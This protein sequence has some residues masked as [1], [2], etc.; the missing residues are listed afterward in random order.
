LPEQ[1]SVSGKERYEF[2][3]FLVDADKQLLLRDGE[4][5]PVTPKTFQI[6]LALIRHN[7]EVVTKDDLMKEVWPDTFVEEANL[8]RNIFLLRKALGEDPPDH[9]Y[10]VTL[11]GRGYRLAGELRVIP[12][13]GV[14]IV[15]A[16]HSRVELRVE[17]SQAWR[18]FAIAAMLV[19]VLAATALLVWIRRPPVLS[20]KDTLVI[21]D[22]ANSTG[23]AVFDGTL[24]QGLSVQLQ[25]SPYLSLV[26][27]ERIHQ[28]LKLMGRDTGTQ[29]TPAVAREVC[30]RTQSAAFLESSISSLGTKYVIGVKAENCKTGDVVDVEQA[31]AASKEEVLTV[32]TQIAGKF[33]TKIGESLATVE[34]HN[35]SLAEA[36]TPS[37]EALRAY[38]LGWQHMFG[39][40]GAS[41]AIPYFKRAIDLDPNFASAYAMAG[42]AYGDMGESS[43]SA[44][45]LT[46]AYALRARTSDRERLFI[47]VNHDMQVSGDLETARQTAEVWAQTYPRDVVPQML[48]SFLYQELGK[49]EKSL[50]AG[51]AAIRL[52]P[53]SVPGYA[54]LAW[55]YVLLDRYQEA[56]N[57]VQ[58]AL[59]RNLDFPDLH[60]L[61]YDLAFM[62]GDRSA[63]QRALPEAEG[64]AGAQHWLLQR[65]SCVLA[66]SG[67]IREAENVSRHAARLA[68]QENQKERAALYLAAIASREALLENEEAAT[69]AAESALKTSTDRDVEYGA[70]FAFAVSRNQSKA[71]ALL[72]DLERRYPQ[73]TFVKFSYAPTIR[74]VL[75]LN[76]GD[77]A[78]AIEELQ[79]SPQYDLAIEGTWAGFFGEMYPS[80]VRGQAYLAAHRGVE[81][82][83]QFENILAHRGLVGSD[84]VS[85]M[86]RL[87]LARS[88]VAAGDASKAKSIY[89]SFFAL[90][91]DGDPENRTLRL[92]QKEYT[93][94]P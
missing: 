76:A 35:T 34:R 53:D 2:G 62:K 31:E 5:V 60:L 65:Q 64:K 44:E 14:S 67:H 23:D 84:F 4:Q 48:L 42:R 73:D 43:A 45:S 26:S 8:S 19:L 18:W 58:L 47:T 11:P 94:L 50:E 70:A 59:D 88:L 27:D 38:S 93:S 89:E 29:L 51:K 40:E 7:K 25:Q 46:K 28:T 3:P 39:A 16:S 85:A 71:S 86:A 69:Q 63:M 9:R 79:N 22:F 36:T 6:L 72:S 30:E 80:Y 37:L 15:A 13:Q 1:D 81:A 61:Q 12:D 20:E 77:S 56:E 82:A 41:E 57:T 68:E 74:A 24:R 92:T 52:D 87:Q 55:A 83:A 75:A 54:N 32:L 17:E 21:A 91:K 10:I 66:Y 90:W 33:R 49:H 78:K